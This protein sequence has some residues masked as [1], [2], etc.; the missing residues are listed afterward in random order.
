M[1]VLGFLSFILRALLPALAEAREAA[2]GHVE[3]DSDPDVR[4]DFWSS[5]RL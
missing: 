1:T 4:R 3:V 2:R 5:E